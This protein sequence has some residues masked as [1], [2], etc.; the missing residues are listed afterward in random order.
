MLWM[1]PLPAGKEMMHTVI[2]SYVFWMI[3]LMG[4]RDVEMSVCPMSSSRF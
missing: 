2:A 3:I 4:F 1:Q